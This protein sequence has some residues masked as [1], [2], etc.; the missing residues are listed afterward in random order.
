MKTL[1]RKS[2]R[3]IIPYKPG[4]PI[5]ELERE[6][7]IKNIIKLASNENPL[8]PSKRA[9]NAIRNFAP[10]VNRYPDG[11][12]FYLKKKLAKSLGLSMDN[13]IIGNGSNEIIE[14]IV[15]AFLEEGDEVILSEPSFLVYGLIAEVAGA[16]IKKTDLKN[17]KYNLGAIRA[18]ISKNTKII[19]IANPNNPTGTYV[20]E[21]EFKEFL[22][23]IR[24]D[25]IVVMDEAY[26]EFVEENDF[27]KTLEYL[28]KYNVVVLR[29][30]SK[31]HGLS[32]LRIGYGIANKRLVY[33]MNKVRQPFNV[34]SIAQIAALASLED[35]A[36][37]EKVKDLIKQQKRF[38]Y[39]GFKNLGLEF[40]P[41]AANF[42]LVNVRQPAKIVF[43][44][45]LKKGVI[46]RDMNAYNLPNWL[47]V[48]IGAQKENIRFLRALKQ[49]LRVGGRR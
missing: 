17:F 38:L 21:E 3:N 23:N 31:A 24:K 14:L 26:Y 11:A 20:T 44:K 7:G 42:I 36:H 33:F 46:V 47:R 28:D 13:L 16:R 1:A 49:V 6:M 18:N 22:K 25:I 29:T 9:I 4:K 41:S 15:R 43:K 8:G 30:F 10:L 12:C 19:F 48:T 34:N 45:M 35:E 2:I 27:P 37:I 32:G 40:V 5:E 39:N